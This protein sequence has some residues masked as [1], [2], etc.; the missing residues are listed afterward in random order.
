MSARDELAMT[1]LHHP[2]LPDHEGLYTGLC[3]ECPERPITG[4]H[5]SPSHADH[6]ADAI[7][8]AGY[9]KPRTIDTV[10][11]ANALPAESVIQ[12]DAGLIYEKYADEDGR[13]FDYWLLPGEQRA[14]AA[15][16]IDFPAT[17]LLEP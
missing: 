9:R 2:W 8:A 4:G 11:E 15:A 10:E 1:L 6:L 16:K 13:E 3:P 5:N 12:S 14:Q 17:V 7:L